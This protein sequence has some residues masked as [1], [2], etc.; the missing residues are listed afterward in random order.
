VGLVLIVFL[1]YLAQLIFISQGDKSSEDRLL[2]TIVNF[3]IFTLMAAPVAVY[4][5][6]LFVTSLPDFFPRAGSTDAW[7]GFAGS[8]IGGIMT[9]LALIFSITYSNKEMKSRRII[10]IKPQVV[11]NI[12][13]FDNSDF[14]KVSSD[15]IGYYI[16][17][18]L[19]CISNYP[20]SRV[21]INSLQCLFLDNLNNVLYTQDEVIDERTNRFILTARDNFQFL[22]YLLI[23]PDNQVI[24]LLENSTLLKL[25]VESEYVDLD[26][27]C[28]YYQTH[29]AL[30]RVY[31][32]DLMINWLE[33]L[34][35][36]N[37]EELVMKKINQIY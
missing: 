16:T 27:Y 28:I 37:I 8:I 5:T 33:C 20:A 14:A 6:L 1:V 23:D 9:I 22:V 31:D 13:K 25:R 4:A 18:E 21:K 19:K 29:T 2:N 15:V 10:E 17:M 11:S 30:F 7:I 32:K 24:E 3:A 35:D 34:G 12:L 26:N 36:V